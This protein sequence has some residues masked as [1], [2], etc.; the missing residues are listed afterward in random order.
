MSPGDD[1][2]DAKIEHE[3]VSK[4]S[5]DKANENKDF[6]HSHQE[7]RPATPEPDSGRGD[8]D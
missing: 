5:R 8:R 6:S 3:T 1:E 7:P 2:E 4:V